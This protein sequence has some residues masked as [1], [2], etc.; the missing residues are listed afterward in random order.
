MEPVEESVLQHGVV[1]DNNVERE[2]HNRSANN[3]VLYLWRQSGFVTSG[4]LNRAKRTTDCA[5]IGH[6]KAGLGRYA[7]TS[8]QAQLP[9]PGPG[10]RNG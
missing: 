6:G 8:R 10:S 2:V 5:D 4:H 7:L 9:A 3:D 1:G